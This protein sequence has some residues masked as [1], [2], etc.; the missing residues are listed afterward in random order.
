[1]QLT[2]GRNLNERDKGVV[3]GRKLPAYS[4]CLHCKEVDIQ[5]K[6]NYG[7]HTILTNEALV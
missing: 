6:N 2:S 5:Y 3:M 4:P 1:M 7:I